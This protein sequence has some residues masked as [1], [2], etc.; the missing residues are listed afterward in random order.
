MPE[1]DKAVWAE[2]RSLAAVAARTAR[3]LTGEL[4]GQPG[5]C[6]PVDVDEDTAPGM[7]Q[8]LIACKLAGF[9]TENSQA[10]S[11]EPGYDGAG[12]RQVA[13]VDGP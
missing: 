12:W 9:L 7:T 6:G 2:A 13:A 4:A 5:Y 8:V 1:A 3:W 10:G 11:D